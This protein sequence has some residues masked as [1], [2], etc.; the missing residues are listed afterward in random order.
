MHERKGVLL[1]WTTREL[2]STPQSW[3]LL[4]EPFAK[5]GRGATAPTQPQ[6]SVIPFTACS[7]LHFQ[8][9]K[10]WQWIP[11]SSKGDLQLL[12]QQH[13]RQGLQGGLCQTWLLTAVKPPGTTAWGGMG[14]QLLPFTQG[15]AGEG[16][17]EATAML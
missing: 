12:P 13:H 3:Y 17:G 5:H 1:K 4:Q 10:T 9:A 7:A 2:D 8:S 6:A 11:W 16:L 15:P 14:E